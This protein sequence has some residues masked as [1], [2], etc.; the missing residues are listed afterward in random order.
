MELE[1]EGSLEEQ[2]GVIKSAVRRHECTLYGNGQPGIVDFISQTRGQFRLIV[3]LLTFIL[4]LIGVYIGLEANHQIK[5]GEIN[6]GCG[7]VMA[8]NQMS[9]E[10]RSTW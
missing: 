7:P 2:M 1:I 6:I 4:A 8:H 9:T 10:K 5:L 3:W